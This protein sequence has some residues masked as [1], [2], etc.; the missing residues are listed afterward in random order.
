M[1][2]WREAI[3]LMM[4]TGFVWYLFLTPQQGSGAVDTRAEL[5]L[6][7]GKQALDAARESAK[8][9]GRSLFMP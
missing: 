1:S 3:L 4:V 5:D 2:R 6:R 8:Q 9:A 7:V